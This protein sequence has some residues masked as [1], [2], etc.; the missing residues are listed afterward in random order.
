MVTR[1]ELEDVLDQKLEKNNKYLLEAIGKEFLKVQVHW[2]KEIQKG[3]KGVRD[4][5]KD[6]RKDLGLPPK[7]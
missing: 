7:S 1:K 3:F 6:L 5:I 4:D 2:S